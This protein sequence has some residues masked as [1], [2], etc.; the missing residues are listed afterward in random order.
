MVDAV[1]GDFGESW[2]DLSNYPLGETLPVSDFFEVVN[3]KSS[4]EKNYI[5]GITPYISSGDLTNSI[6][7]LVE[8][9]ENE[10]F[11]SGAITVTAF[12]QAYVQPWPFMA[13]GNGGSAVRVLIPKY[14][15]SFNDLVW[16][17]SQIN[18][19][20]LR[21]F[22]GRMAIKSRLVRLDITSPSKKLNDTGKSISE[23]IGEFHSSLIELSGTA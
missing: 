3:G 17:A 4:G 1:L 22:Y 11:P 20:R 9:E 18:A 23:R 7:R 19:Q 5:E 12:G 2:D 8:S 10:M 21:F 16:F 15:M 14:K 6:I 13:R